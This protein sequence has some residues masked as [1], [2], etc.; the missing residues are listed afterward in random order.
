MRDG[1]VKVAAGTPEIRVADCRYNAEQIF[2]LMRE[3]DKQGVRVL[4]L[5]ELCLTGYTCGDLFLQD[6]LLKGAEEGLAT[7][8]EATKNLD[9]LTALGLPVKNPWDGKLYNCA[10]VIHRGEIRGLVPKTWLPNYG[11]FYEMRWF[12][13]GKD[14]DASV[15]LCG[16]SV[17][18]CTNLVWACDTMPDLVVGVELCEDLWASTPPSVALAQAG[19]TVILNLSAS[20]ETI[21][22]QA[23]R[24]DD[25]RQAVAAAFQQRTI[26]ETVQAG[27]QRQRRIPA[28]GS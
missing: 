1:F 7:I 18:L 24:R 8:L 19:A 4:A 17:S 13:S 27:T 12:A 26:Q 3:A 15:E 5:P 10:A 28:I 2:T 11:E 20:D 14:L 9:M 6:T 23:Y 16:Q 22:K 21:G 25:G